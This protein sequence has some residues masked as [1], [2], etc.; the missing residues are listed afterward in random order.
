MHSLNL[1][2]HFLTKGTLSS[3][4][5]DLSLNVE[6]HSH[7]CSVGGAYIVHGSSY[8]ARQSILYK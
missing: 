6:R 7:M 3:K 2:Y 8:D 5:V 1:I 4:I